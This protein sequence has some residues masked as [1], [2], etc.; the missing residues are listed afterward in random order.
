MSWSRT[1][2]SWLLSLKWTVSC[3]VSGFD[4]P[5]N[6]EV[7]PTLTRARYKSRDLLDLGNLQV[8]HQ[9]SPTGNEC[10]LQYCCRSTV[11][12]MVPYQIAIAKRS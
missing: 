2:F 6:L 1:I 12:L 9:V 11:Y 5:I 10:G 4:L 8:I 3:F 7:K